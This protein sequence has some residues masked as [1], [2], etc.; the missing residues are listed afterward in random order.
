MVCKANK[1]ILYLR[2]ISALS[3][4]E[5]LNTFLPLF[6]QIRA[7]DILDIILVATLLY[8][9]YSLLKGSVAINIL[10]GIATIYLIWKLVEILH[11][12]LLSQILGAFIG[13]G[14][15][16][17]I[18]VFQPEIRQFLL[19]FGTLK[20]IERWSAVSKLMSKHFDSKLPPLNIAALVQACEH[21]AESKT[22]ALIVITQK[23]ELKQVFDSGERIDAVLSKQLIE[24]IFYKNSPLH[25]GA[26]II[27]N[28]RI[29]AASCILP[30]SN[31]KQL[32]PNLGLRHRAALG[33]TER[34]D[35]LAVVVSEETG[36][37]SVVRHAQLQRHLNGFELRSLLEEFYTDSSKKYIG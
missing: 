24:N 13:V 5:V 18:I 20:N 26:V 22:G 9:L 17:L 15:I 37:I 36:A 6:I 4:M 7:L 33:L 2:A 34:T 29:K 31:S 12:E 10:L 21:M 23:H 14:F 30:V 11:M 16:A 8:M 32:A 19:F 25:D 35:A 3:L 27:S 28:N 1:K